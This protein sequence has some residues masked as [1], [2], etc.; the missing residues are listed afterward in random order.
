LKKLLIVSSL[1]CICSLMLLL[2]S[3]EEF[4][5]F[6]LLIHFGTLLAW[7]AIT[8]FSFSA[9]LLVQHYR[10][11]KIIQFIVLILSVLWILV[12]ISISGNT[13]LSFSDSETF[14]IWL[15]YT[16]LI[17]FTTLFTLL[18]AGIKSTLKSPSS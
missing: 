4:L 7:I 13:S 2:V 11:I 15:F 6:N 3:G 12:S 10:Q 9:Y 18:Y 17:I 16:S 5:S 14:R 8:S 1:I